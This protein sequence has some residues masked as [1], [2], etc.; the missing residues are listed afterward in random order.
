MSNLAEMSQEVSALVAAAA[1]SVVGVGHNGSGVVVDAGVVVTNAHNLRG[2]PVVT[3]SDGSVATASVAGSDIDGDLAVLTVPTG[4]APAL[5]W[6]EGPAMLGQI[7]IGISRPGGRALRAGLGSVSGL[8]LAFRGPE[9]RLVKG[10]LEHTAPLAHG[11]SG[12]PVLDAEGKLLG[13]NTH[14]PGEG[15][16]LAL[17]AG[18]ELRARVEALAQ[19]QAPRRL[20]LGIA[21]APPKVARHLRQA[22]G[23]PAREGLLVHE[24]DPAGPAARAGV[25][26]GDLVVSVGGQAVSEV[27]ELAAALQHAAGPGPVALVVVRGADEVTLEVDLGQ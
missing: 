3:F 19:G 25:R 21:L 6:A 12:G 8:D 9:G 11:S 2:S 27:D 16:Y 24:V 18:P 10:A 14:R 1:T 15:V 17:P 26:R 13:I 5:A 23:L 7:V 22:V 20:R 4:D